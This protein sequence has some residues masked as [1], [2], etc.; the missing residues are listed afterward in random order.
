MCHVRIL[1]G[2]V[3]DRTRLFVKNA[4]AADTVMRAMGLFWEIR[5]TVGRTAVNHGIKVRL[6]YFPLLILENL[7]TE[8]L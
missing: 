5:S 4:V 7:H 2:L 6:L 3:S 1:L 8:I